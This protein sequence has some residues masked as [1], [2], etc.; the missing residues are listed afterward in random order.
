MITLGISA[1][2]H[3]SAV[4]ILQDE[5]I[6]FALQEERLDLCKIGG[7]GIL[8]I[9]AYSALLYFL[10]LFNTCI[11]LRF[12]FLKSFTHFISHLAST[13]FYFKPTNLYFGKCT[14]FV[15]KI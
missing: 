11:L 8:L 9:S 10:L 3:D 2:Y 15:R 12:Y 1:Y 7:G 14:I 13:H 5:K 6:I 4:A